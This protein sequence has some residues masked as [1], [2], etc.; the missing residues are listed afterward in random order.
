[1]A[2][3]WS[4]RQSASRYSVPR[5][6][7]T[8]GGGSLGF[9]FLITKLNNISIIFCL[10]LCSHCLSSSFAQFYL[11]CFRCYRRISFHFKF[12]LNAVY[13]KVTIFTRLQWNVLKGRID[14]ECLAPLPLVPSLTLFAPHTSSCVHLLLVEP[15]YLKAASLEWAWLADITLLCQLA[16]GGEE[17]PGGGVLHTTGRGSF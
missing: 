16:G 1:M 2:E 5:S 7:L 15:C 10:S 3:T 11:L 14:F 17:E 12:T 9:I 6:I 8:N 13:F 4:K